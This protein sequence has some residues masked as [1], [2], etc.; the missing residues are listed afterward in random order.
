[1]RKILY[2]PGFGAGWSSWNTSTEALRKFVLEYLPIVKFIEEGGSFTYADAHNEPPHPLLK[3]LQDECQARFGED[4]CVLG[5]TQLQVAEVEGQVRIEEYDGS[6]SYVTR[7]TET[8]W[9]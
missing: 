4:A 8:G 6:E 2:S 9:L 5:A 3:Q 7:D 1:M